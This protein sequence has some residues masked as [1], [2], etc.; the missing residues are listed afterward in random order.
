MTTAFVVTSRQ[1]SAS[2]RENRD[3]R[4]VVKAVFGGEQSEEAP[5]IDEDALHLPR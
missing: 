4:V 2:A 1:R 5:A 3:P